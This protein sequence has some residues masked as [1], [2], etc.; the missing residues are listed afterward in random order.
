MKHFRGV[1]E[2][3]ILHF[4]HVPPKEFSRN[5]ERKK[6]GM[7]I[8]ATLYIPGSMPNFNPN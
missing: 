3:K 7:A 6:L 8:G 1:H 5:L 4:F 2:E